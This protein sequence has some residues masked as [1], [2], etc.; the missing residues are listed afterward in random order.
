MYRKKVGTVNPHQ[1]PEPL[2]RRADE[3][4]TYYK[5]RGMI[6]I[7]EL[8]YLAC[9]LLNDEHGINSYAWEI[10]EDALLLGNIRD[11]SYVVKATEGRYY[12]TEEDFIKLT[13]P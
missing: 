10:L 9:V 11:L 3:I 1:I 12:I 5:E 6:D 13:I 8:R 2:A 4:S 7:Y